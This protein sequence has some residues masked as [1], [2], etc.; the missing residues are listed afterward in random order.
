LEDFKIEKLEDYPFLKY[1]FYILHSKF[2]INHSH[3]YAIKKAPELASEAF[4]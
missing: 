3:Y 1:Q 2:Y 4:I